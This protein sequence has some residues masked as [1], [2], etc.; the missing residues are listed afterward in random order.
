MALVGRCGCVVCER[1]S[2]SVHLFQRFRAVFY[3]SPR[4]VC[5]WPA[6]Q[7][8]AGF[9]PVKACLRVNT[10]GQLLLFFFYCDQPGA[11]CYLYFLLQRAVRYR[12]S[13]ESSPCHETVCGEF[14]L[15]LYCMRVS[16]TRCASVFYCGASAGPLSVVGAQCI[17]AS[18]RARRLYV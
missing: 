5:A 11:G 15:E 7:A 2:E 9:S 14:V 8:R 4:L 12:L 17:R 6:S 10:A 13:R 18:F 3:R 16:A 1:E